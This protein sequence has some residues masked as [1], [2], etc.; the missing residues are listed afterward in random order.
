MKTRITLSHFLIVL[1][2]AH[3][4]AWELVNGQSKKKTIL[5]FCFKR[6][7]SSSRVREVRI[8]TGTATMPVYKKNSTTATALLVW[9]AYRSCVE[10][11][12]LMS[13]ENYFSLSVPSHFPLLLLIRLLYAKVQPCSDCRLTGC[14]TVQW[15]RLTSAFR[16]NVLLEKYHSMSINDRLNGLQR[17]FLSKSFKSYERKVN[18]PPPLQASV[19]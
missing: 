13:L 3:L 9:V 17:Y 16:T 8:R 1:K 7:V 14:V 6:Q 2:L 4:L 12:Q 11:K 15:N 10:F 19:L 18:N 5:T